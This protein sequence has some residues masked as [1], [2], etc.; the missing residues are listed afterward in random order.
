MAPEQ[1]QGHDTDFRSDIFSLGAVLYEMVTGHSA[2]QAPTKASLIAKI[3]ESEPPTL[4][5]AGVTAPPGLDYLIRTCLTKAPELR[6]QAAQDVVLGL[7]RVFDERLNEATITRAGT[8][9]R[10]WGYGL[11]AALLA[12]L[13]TAI[14]V[15][16]G[17]IGPSGRSSG[18]ASTSRSPNGSG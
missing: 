4:S 16:L 9:P 11:A 1:L 5:A 10:F 6:W 2:F 14:A 3:L 18:H 13:A 15:V 8:P 17:R 7:Q 12:V